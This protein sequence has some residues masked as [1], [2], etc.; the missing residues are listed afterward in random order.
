MT[1]VVWFTFLVSSCYL[2]SSD[3][4]THL[5]PSEGPPPLCSTVDFLLVVSHS[6]SPFYVRSV[7]LIVRLSG[8]SL[9]LV[10][11][12]LLTFFKS[13]WP[14]VSNIPSS[15]T[16]SLHPVRL[17][18]LEIPVTFRVSKYIHH[19]ISLNKTFLER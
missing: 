2:L 13:H 6:I 1:L 11:T 9:S 12:S 7:F 8:I 14:R 18:K 16:G 10:L 15:D 17:L 5:I 19:C 3:W 4:F